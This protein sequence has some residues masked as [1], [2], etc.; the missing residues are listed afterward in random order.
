MK[1]T[2]KQ[3]MLIIFSFY[4]VS[5]IAQEK[6]YDA[7]FKNEQL[8]EGWTQSPGYGE[9][10][11]K[12]QDDML[13][14]Y[15]NKKGDQA[16][17][18]V[19]ELDLKHY[20]K[21]LLILNYQQ[22]Q[23][24]AKV[25]A[26]DILFK[27][28][29]SK[30]WVLLKSYSQRQKSFICDTL[31][32]PNAFKEDLVQFAIR[33][34]NNGGKGIYIK[35]F[36]VSE[37]HL[38]HE[39]VSDI[40]ET[41]LTSSR[42]TLSWDVPQ[43]VQKCN[44]ALFDKN[45]QY[46]K[47]LALQTLEVMP[48]DDLFSVTFD[49]LDMQT[50]YYVS[51]T[52]DCG[53]GDL[54]PQ[55][56]YSFKTLCGSISKG[57]KN[58]IDNKDAIECWIKSGTNE[59]FVPEL[60]W[61]Y[62]NE[63][64]EQ[65][66]PDK[67]ICMTNNKGDYSY[68]IAPE[69]HTNS[70]SNLMLSMEV[71]SKENSSYGRQYKGVFTV[72]I[73]TDVSDYTTF[74]PITTLDVT[75]QDDW[76]R[77]KVG[78]S[79]YTG[80]AFGS[81]GKHIALKTG[82]RSD[83]VKVYFDN[84]EIKE[85]EC[86]PPLNNR[87]ENI[88]AH[89]A[90]VIWDEVGLS[91]KWYVKQ[92]TQPLEEEALELLLDSDLKETTTRYVDLTNL[93]SNTHYYVYIKGDCGEWSSVVSFKTPNSI[94]LVDNSYKNT[95][96]SKPQGWVLSGWDVKKN[97]EVTYDSRKSQYITDSQHN[98]SGTVSGCLKLKQ[99]S[100]W[101]TKVNPFIIMPEVE[102]TSFA[103][104][105]LKLQLKEA[106]TSMPICIGICENQDIR[107]VQKIGQV[108]P[109]VA[110]QYES[111]YLPLSAYIGKGKCIAIYTDLNVQ[112]SESNAIYVDDIHIEEMNDFVPIT[113]IYAKS[114]VAKSAILEWD[115][116]SKN[117]E[118]N[119]KVFKNEVEEVEH[120]SSFSFQKLQYNKHSIVLSS[121]EANTTYFCY[122]RNTAKQGEW[123]LFKLHTLS[124]I[125][126]PYHNDFSQESI[127]INP[128][129][130]MV[131]NVSDPK[132]TPFVANWSYNVNIDG[133]TSPSLLMEGGCNDY[134]YAILPEIKNVES[135]N[136][137]EMHFIGYAAKY[138]SYGHSN[139]KELIVGVY[140]DP[141]NLDSFEAIDTVCFPIF[142]QAQK[143]YI[144]FKSYQGKSKNIGFKTQTSGDNKVYIDNIKINKFSECGFIYGISPDYIHGNEARFTWQS[145]GSETQW[146]IKLFDSTLGDN[147]TLETK[148]VLSQHAMNKTSI[149][150]NSLNPLTTYYFAIR[151]V[152]GTNHGEWS[153]LQSFT[154]AC[155]DSYPIPFNENFNSYEEES[156]PECWL[157]KRAE[158]SYYQSLPSV[159]S[160]TNSSYSPIPDHSYGSQ[161][162][163][164][165]FYIT[166]S[167]GA[168]SYTILPPLD[169][170]LKT[171]QLSLFAWTYRNIE[172]NPAYLEIGVMESV[173]E[174]F[175]NPEIA[176]SDQVCND[177]LF[178]P[179]EKIYLKESK[180][181]QEI[182]VD[183]SQYIGK[184]KR[185]AL[186]SGFYKEYADSYIYID[187]I[188]IAKLPKLPKI[189]S[190]N[191]ERITYKEALLKFTKGLENKWDLKLSTKQIGDLEQ[192]KGDVIDKTIHK[193]PYKL[194]HLNPQTDYYLYVR[195]YLSSSEKSVWSD[196]YHFKTYAAPKHIVYH[197]N[198]ESYSLDSL[199]E[200][201]LFVGSSSPIA[202]IHTTSRKTI[203]YETP[204]NA[205]CLLLSNTSKYDGGNKVCSS[206]VVLPEMDIDHINQTQLRFKASTL[207]QYRGQFSVG[208][209]SDPQDLSTYKEVF[210]GKVPKYSTMSEKWVEYVI[211][212]SD[213]QYD[214]YGE[215]G[216]YI[217][218]SIKNGQ[219]IYQ[220]NQVG[221]NEIYLDDC[222][223]P[224][225]L[226]CDTVGENNCKLSWQ[227]NNK[228]VSW[229]IA[230]FEDKAASEQALK[231]A[232][233]VASSQTNTISI[234]KLQA[235]T[236]YYAY[237]RSRR[238]SKVSHWSQS[239]VFHTKVPTILEIPFYDGFD[240]ET[241]TVDYLVPSN[242]NVITDEGKNVTIGGES[243]QLGSNSSF[244]C[245]YWDD[246]FEGNRSVRI[247]QKSYLVT[248]KLNVQDIHNLAISFYASTTNLSSAIEIGVLE[249]LY[250]LDTYYCLDK[251]IPFTK[252]WYYYERSFKDLS[253][254]L[255]AKYIVIKASE[256]KN[257]VKTIY[258]SDIYVDNIN[259]ASVNSSWTPTH[260]TVHHIKDTQAEIQMSDVSAAKKWNYRLNHTAPIYSTS[261]LPIQ[262][263]SLSPQTKYCVEVQSELIDGSQS[264]WSDS[265]IFYTA[266]VAAEL[267]YQC[268]FED[269]EENARW[270]LD[271]SSKTQTLS[272][273]YWV[274]DT[275]TWNAE[276]G[277]SLYI[278][279][280]AKH[281]Y[282][283]SDE[284]ISHVKASRSVC[285]KQSGIYD[286]N[287]DWKSYGKNQKSYQPYTK[288]RVY[289]L[290]YDITM[291]ESGLIFYD[292]HNNQLSSQELELYTLANALYRE[293]EWQTFESQLMIKNP[294]YYK[295]VFIWDNAK[296]ITSGYKNPAAID[297]ISISKATCTN[298]EQLSIESISPQTVSLNW[299]GE[300]ENGWEIELL[301]IQKDKA[302]VSKDHIV[303][304]QN[305][306]LNKITLQ[307]LLA[308]GSYRC[309]ISSQ[310]S[311]SSSEHSTF[312]DFSLPCETQ[313]LP[314]YEDF[315]DNY[316]RY[317]LHMDCW[318]T[319]TTF[320]GSYYYKKKGEVD[321]DTV[322][323]L[324]PLDYIVLP[325]MGDDLSKLQ[326]SFE[327]SLEC[328]STTKDL[329]F[330]VG[331][332]S[333]YEDEASFEIYKKINLKHLSKDRNN[334][335]FEPITI[336]FKEYLGHGKFIAI[337]ANKGKLLLDNFRV[338]TVSSCLEPINLTTIK[339]SS[340]SLDIA[341]EADINNDYTV[342]VA[343]ELLS[344]DE[345]RLLNSSKIVKKIAVNQALSAHVGGLISSSDY[346]IYIKPNCGS[347][348]SRW[349]KVLHSSTLCGLFASNDLQESFDN[350]E[351]PTCWHTALGKWEDVSKNEDDLILSNNTKIK[352]VENQGFKSPH[353]HFQ[354]TNIS[355]KNPRTAW[356]ISPEINLDQSKLL[357]FD[358]TMTD[359]NGEKYQS[360]DDNKSRLMVVIS[361][362]HG[363]T[364][365]IINNAN[366]KFHGQQNIDQFS[367]EV[368][369]ILLDLSP[370]QN[371][372]VQFAFY[373]ESYSYNKSV[374]LNI[375]NVSLVD[376][377][378][379]EY[380]DQGFEHRDYDGFGFHFDYLEMTPGQKKC[381]RIAPC[382]DSQEL[383]S[384]ITLNLE[385]L[386]IIRDTLDIQYC[387]NEGYHENGFDL[388]SPGIYYRSLISTQGS[389]SIVIYNMKELPVYS[390]SEDISI[391]YGKT[392]EF[393]GENY[394]TSTHLKHLFK[395]VDGCD[396]MVSINLTVVP[397][398]YF[399]FEKT[400]ETKELPYI[401]LGKT[402]PK[403]TK[404]GFYQDTLEIKDPEGCISYSILKLTIKLSDHLEDL[405]Y[406]NFSITPSCIHKGESFVIE[407][408]G[409]FSRNVVD[410]YDSKGIRIYSHTYNELPI[411]IEGGIDNSGVYTLV[412]QNQHK[413]IIKKIIVE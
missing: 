174:T 80:D 263:H 238:S 96:D 60:S 23:L 81:V 37:S 92:S 310:C 397:P 223:Q 300:A 210:T 47:L 183:F 209:I 323:V 247:K 73:M 242:W 211:P 69:V 214:S 126:I 254:G 316:Y 84:I 257:R 204:N 117:Q 290:P 283:F 294:G 361:S 125:S 384:L 77:V 357:K 108:S 345:L 24:D 371:Q 282:Q 169:A 45:P 382:Y 350:K 234:D 285:I 175:E 160:T 250:D 139:T 299:L 381:Q 354:L 402:Y 356:L 265:I 163:Y 165:V 159:I 82:L 167:H 41:D 59:A 119:I 333:N 32:I 118:W 248:S 109:K 116:Y 394:D 168:Y 79:Q 390:Q 136:Q 355:W 138:S 343:S 22:K 298:A 173:D 78:F 187:D 154:T 153:S 112:P 202:S 158:M 236:I 398:E 57:Y 188:S 330:S 103:H 122:I 413:K 132:H 375:D 206:Y 91:T 133:C 228:N 33:A 216:K 205:H 366:W 149:T 30:K 396:S 405:K 49:Q 306:S 328:M 370:Y 225:L 349:S 66:D 243:V 296:N 276:N 123:K 341:W 161:K 141:N 403:G 289:L 2:L 336:R 115:D 48:K 35:Q 301:D 10:F 87:V 311:T 338:T 219:N 4:C 269:T 186:R 291:S 135:I 308:G 170:D 67:C 270:M 75:N 351:I 313:I 197:N 258:P 21:P 93:H 192:D 208:V 406:D 309:Y 55:T 143:V 121:L 230:L 130:W 179:I 321:V 344:S 358:V 319:N 199:P 364:W 191:V 94:A 362:D 360:Y 102:V 142:E 120:N 368:Q 207:N 15:A 101:S 314:Y 373:F 407:G 198:F 71:H 252:E 6:I 342:V 8:P 52:N 7:K 39:K 95:F 367:C 28:K 156:V 240:G 44:I 409:S 114:V 164:G 278:T 203:P 266:A 70:M 232:Q 404:P 255:Q 140:S 68:F 401:Y 322:L 181:W 65:Q 144:S 224:L 146:E 111:F 329:T 348:L 131:G 38:C 391:C 332:M 190:I 189:R 400:I 17:V 295:L 274:V 279:N 26:F 253:V 352:F 180:M 184:G 54:S 100:S 20:V 1:T 107:T 212:L 273:N 227:T 171:L 76:Q 63:E 50:S 410:I 353:V 297:N 85:I 388:V 3:W 53:C 412:I 226:Q 155:P 145:E 27:T 124:Q 380:Q 42:V 56:I 334:Q 152:K 383:D 249:S 359:D 324:K 411:T 19:L 399:N 305:V 31:E 408:I 318:Y 262:L 369:S 16:Q 260:L 229:E 275:M 40:I 129:Y 337:K 272:L 286:I 281:T 90:R 74:V 392:Y 245:V 134:V 106:L 98:S 326:L 83:Y 61:D 213:Y 12:V 14:F 312:I 105:A 88:Q 34:R 182:V 194:T 307:N 374:Y 287:F 110:N 215:E 293:E 376:Y 29:T 99:I 372:V 386:P 377:K 185:I 201:W 288:L 25:D 246:V 378:S 385:V 339:S 379:I 127:S 196:V 237:V 302:K 172:K 148:K 251:I 176:Y 346:W 244:A 331:I 86:L 267:P 363:H 233:I 280:D 259:I 303:S 387:A 389:D 13:L 147:E 395:T 166:G 5:L 113:S 178:T 218:I 271:N 327:S 261:Q 239:C 200:D 64:R 137:L 231:N 46:N 317:D 128:Q 277:Q 195:R 268:N 36:L 292:A 335:L 193:I 304:T 235:G 72:G 62:P 264:E 315:S 347:G 97:C 11:W 43:Y 9:S 151:S 284:A 325:Y 89:Q 220:P 150:F 241:D 222:V 58:F 365:Q 256:S 177:K 393:E 162:G 340:N 104:Y 18:K 157:V 320:N 217:A 51:I 221:L